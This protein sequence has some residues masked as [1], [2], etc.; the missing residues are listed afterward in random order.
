M[1]CLHFALEPLPASVMSICLYAQFLSRSF[2][3]V[4]SIHNYISGV[5]T[6]HLL[7]DVPYIAEKSVELRMTLQGL[8]RT[9]PHCVRQAAPLTPK[10]LSLIYVNLS[11]FEPIQGTMWA[12]L[13]IAFFTLSRKSNLVVTG[14]KKFDANKQLCRSDVLV[15]AHGLL[16]QFRWSKTNQ[17]G[18]K[19]LLVPVKEIPG[20]CLCPVKAYKN[21][22]KLLPG[23]PSCPA[24][25][26]PGQKPVSYTLLQ[27]FIKTNVAKLGLDPRCFSSHSLRRAGATWAFKSQ[28]PGELIQTHGD[29]A[30]QAYLRYIE[31]S[32]PQ[33]VQVAEQMTS[34]IV[35]MGL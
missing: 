10:L 27:K 30:S 26:L 3:A 35:K 21:M 31:I 5:R 24:F 14:S 11:V 7:V 9:K 28:V 33:R 15:G 18:N 20:S 16:V 6:L 13:L 25:M 12:L 4:S 1:F 17:F 8:K 34:E 32:L 23:S 29:W 2:K 22:V 19:K